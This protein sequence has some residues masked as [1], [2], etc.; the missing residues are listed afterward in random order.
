MTTT[1]LSRQER[2]V[3]WLYGGEGMTVNQVALELALAEETTKSYVKRIREKLRQRG[4]D[5][6]TRVE[7]FLA[8]MVN[9]EDVPGC[10]QTRRFLLR[11]LT[12][13]D[14]QYLN[15]LTRPEYEI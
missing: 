13:P 1:H 4:V 5:A 11:H 2:R 14:P 7:L 10:A 9:C 6:S 3:L 12:Q 15:A 8:A